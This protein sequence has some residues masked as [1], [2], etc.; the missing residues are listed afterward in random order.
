MAVIK[1]HG[2]YFLTG[3]LRSGKGLT[4][5]SKIQEILLD[6]RKVATNRDL[7]LE[8]LLPANNKT[9]NVI[10]LPDKPNIKDLENIGL[11]YD[12]DDP[13]HYDETKFGLLDLDELATFFNARSWNDK[14]RKEVIDWLLM[15]GKKRWILMLTIQ[16]L[17][18]LDK[19]I[20]AALAGQ[21]IVRCKSLSKYS[22][23]VLSPLYKLFTGRPLTLPK[24]Y[25]A[26]VKIGQEKRSHVYDRWLHIGT[27]LYNAY[28]TSQVYLDRESLHATQLCTMLSPWYIKGR[29]LPKKDIHYYRKIISSKLEYLVYASL[30][31][32]TT[33]SVAFG[34]SLYNSF[35]SKTEQVL[36][37]QSHVAKLESNFLEKFP[38]IPEVQKIEKIA[39]TDI[40]AN[41][42]SQFYISGSYSTP[43]GRQYMLSNNEKVFKTTEFFPR[44]SRIKSINKCALTVV[45]DNCTY[46]FDCNQKLD[47][48]VTTARGD[49]DIESSDGGLLNSVTSSLF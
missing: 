33:S 37:L 42:Y 19:Q 32:F 40:D 9:A 23:P 22:I 12:H 7:K 1:E 28:N 10:R 44:T 11:G 36:V 21:F 26:V 34:F 18:L 39:C 31:A 48:S 17:E 6:G 14:G 29:Y 46:D 8:H 4:A 49:A 5:V 45:I 47:I 13:E 27:S 15:S 3:T 43:K 20:K 38:K 35:T 2:I 24:S 25:L 16:D 30:L 41:K